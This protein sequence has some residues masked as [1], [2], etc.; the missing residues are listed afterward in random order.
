MTPVCFGTQKLQREH[1]G[2]IITWKEAIC[3][4]HEDG[5]I[6]KDEHSHT[7]C[8]IYLEFGSKLLHFQAIAD[9]NDEDTMTATSR[10]RN[11]LLILFEDPNTRQRRVLCVKMEAGFLAEISR[12]LLAHSGGFSLGRGGDARDSTAMYRDRIAVVS[13]RN[14]S[15]DLGHYCVLRIVDVREDVMFSTEYA[16]NVDEESEEDEDD[17]ADEYGQVQDVVSDKDH[18]DDEDDMERR[19]ER[20][21]RHEWIPARQI[22]RRGRLIHLKDVMGQRMACRILAMDHA[23]IVLG[24]GPRMVKILSLV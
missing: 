21:I 3:L 10:R 20:P 7:L 18:Q 19:Q 23:R 8:H 14:C 5:V 6:I 22:Q 9:G 12:E 13:H 2:S 1:G 17:S 4:G 15:S 11:E 16:Q 24:V